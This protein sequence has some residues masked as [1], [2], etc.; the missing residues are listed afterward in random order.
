M[1]FSRP[2][3]WFGARCTRASRS[4]LVIT[5]RDARGDHWGVVAPRSRRMSARIPARAM[6]YPPSLGGPT[7][8]SRFTYVPPLTHQGPPSLAQRVQ[9]VALRWARVRGRFASSQ[10][11][12]AQFPAHVLGNA[13]R[14]ACLPPYPPSAPPPSFPGLQRKAKPTAKSKEWGG[15]ASD[16]DSL[17]TSSASSCARGGAPLGWVAS[18]LP[19]RAR[20]LENPQ[21]AFSHR[22]GAGGAP[23]KGSGEP[24]CHAIPRVPGS[25]YRARGARA[26]S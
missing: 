25:Y 2:T 18:H 11:K 8:G 14:V 19:D 12:N 3:W 5:G 26:A 7:R 6:G 9:D 23:R 15:G 20:A 10:R 1:F 13:Q 22:K 17:I 21:G 16:A 24:A 4:G